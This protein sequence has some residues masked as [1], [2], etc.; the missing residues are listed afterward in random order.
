MPT[1]TGTAGD[2]VIDTGSRAT[3]SSNMGYSL[4]NSNYVVNAGAGADRIAFQGVSNGSTFNGEDGDDII[5]VDWSATFF[6]SLNAPAV[7]VDGQ[8]VQIN[9]G[10]GADTLTAVTHALIDGGEG[11]DIIQVGRGFG[12]GSAGRGFVIPLGTDTTVRLTGGAGADTFVIAN[13]IGTAVITDFQIGTDRLDFSQSF[14]W[15]FEGGTGPTGRVLIGQQGADT[16]FFSADNIDK[17]FARLV[18][19]DASTIPVSSYLNNAGATPHL[20]TTPVYVFGTPG[21]DTLSGAVVYGGDGNDTLLGTDGDDLLNG[22]AGNDSL[23]GGR[24][25][26]QLTG[27]AGADAFIFAAGDSTGTAIDS[28]ADFQT[29]SDTLVIEGISVSG[30]SLVRTSTGG[31]VV[32]GSH[33][34]GPQT[35]IGVNGAIQAGDI[36]GSGGQ[37]LAAIMLGSEN[38]DTLIGS[39]SNDIVNAGA[40]DDFLTGG[41]GSD[42]LTGGSGADQFIYNAVGESRATT[43]ATDRITDFQTGV[44]LINLNAILPAALRIDMANGDTQVYAIY[45]TSLQYQPG[46]DLAILVTGR[47]QGSDFLLAGRTNI[48]VQMN[49]SSGAD[50]LIGS[51]ADDVISGGAGADALMGGAGADTLRG[52]QGLDQ[53]TGEAGA[54]SF[55]F[56]AGDSTGSAID[57]VADFQTGS[58]RIVL[59]GTVTGLSLVRVGN[60]ATLVFADYASGAQTV[61]GVN[62]TIQAGDVVGAGGQA[63]RANV[64][65]SDGPDVLIGSSLG[66]TI[67]G[68]AE[69]DT[70]TGGGGADVLFG[71]AGG[72]IFVYTAWADSSEAAMDYLAD[73]TSGSDRIDLAGILTG[74]LSIVRLG[75]ASFV[76]APTAGGMLSI[77]ATGAVQGSDVNVGNDANVFILGSAGNDTLIGSV[78]RDRIVGGDGNDTIISVAASFVL[79]NPNT[80]LVSGGAGADLF[81]YRPNIAGHLLAIDDFET[82]VDRLGMGSARSITIIRQEDGS[83]QVSGGYRLNNVAASSITMTALGRDINVTDLDIGYAEGVSM[84][85]SSRADTLIGGIYGDAVIAGAG[86]DT[87]I[88]G[89]AADTLSGEGGADTFVYRASSDSTL[90]GADVITD[91][92]SGMDRIDLTAVRTGASDTFGIAYLNGGSFLFVDLGGNGTNDMLIQLAGTTLVASDIRWSASAGDLEPVVKDAGPE[93]LLVSDDVEGWWTGMVPL[94]DDGMLFLDDGG[95]ASVRGHDWYL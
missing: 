42:F 56:A 61:I 80:D 14:I 51:V 45:G 35:I 83:S 17:V 63:I 66:D 81:T 15:N 37:V 8:A 84:R 18:N 95:T 71:G 48:P 32:F 73:F 64:V 43:G 57:S 90:A 13:P 19:V 87:I 88:G 94:H 16:I 4:F 79:I 70:I 55:I 28:I 44:D 9:G 85:G 54:D 7:L 20:A 24:G 67:N 34:S 68:G 40:G 49:G 53:L 30:L 69:N 52:G 78:G 65:G 5:T 93:V 50:V 75:G 77:A 3:S 76:Y 27:G 1:F 23:R 2:D 11:D 72:D 36:L 82:G 6:P 86:N 74:T 39:R 91:F 47:V 62:G 38:A 59:E 60:G 41:L 31:T 29:G 92:V 10:G 22:G 33:I 26:D 46:S 12:A 89:C 25:L 58:D 21:N